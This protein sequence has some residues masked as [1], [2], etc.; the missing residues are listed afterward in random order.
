MGE[1]TS[2]ALQRAAGR[3]RYRPLML[4]GLL[5]AL[6]VATYAA[7][8]GNR[9]LFHHAADPYIAPVLDNSM[10]QSFPLLPKLFCRSFLLSTYGEYRP[11]GYALL[12]LVRRILPWDSGVAWHGALIALH[13]LTALIVFLTLRMLVSDWA[14]SALSAAYLV[15]PI[16]VFLVNN[17][18][19][20]YF[21]WGLCFSAL[22]LWL[23]LLYLR[24]NGPAYLLVSVV[25]FVVAAF[26]FRHAAVLPA[27]VIVLCLHHAPRP[28]TAAAM[29]V[30]VALAAS[31]AA[32]FQVPV[33]VTLGALCA[34]MLSAGMATGAGK[35]QYLDLAR[36]LPPYVG[37]VALY[38]FV[39]LT[40][41][42]EPLHA[43]TL[44][45][46]KE[47]DMVAPVQPEW[48]WR[49]AHAGSALLLVSFGATVF[50]PLLLLSKRLSR[51][52]VVL[53]AFLCFVS[54]RE[55]LYYR[56]DARYWGRLARL[57]PDHAAVQ[58]NLATALV[59]EG[60]YGAARDLLIRLIVERGIRLS[61]ESGFKNAPL[62]LMVQVKLAEAYA[63]LG[64]DK[65]AGFYFFSATRGHWKFR[66]MRNL[67]TE[68]GDFCFRTG[69]ISVAE[70]NWASGLVLDPYDVR[71]YNN[72]GRTL[73][74]RNFFRAA[75]RHFEYVLSLQPDNVTALYYMA[76]L[77]KVLGRQEDH[78]AYCRRWRA[79]THSAGEPDFQPI[80][81]GFRF[82]PDKMRA[83]FSGNPC[84]MSF[85]LQ[86][87]KAQ[88][89][90]KTYSF[91]E[92]PLSIARYLV[93]QG[94]YT[95]AETYLQQ[96]HEANPGSREAIQ[97]LIEVYG[98][99]NR[100]D[101]AKRMQGLLE[102]LP[103][104]NEAN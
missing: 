95:D 93:G 67:L 104:G 87:Y 39:S 83:W 64:D 80:Y 7:S 37:V 103:S 75:A 33:L 51:F 1:S 6:G 73:T 41:K 49:W 77:S 88:Y 52:V 11:A 43:V 79:V 53:L 23:C 18:N 44:E 21:L 100:P 82:D 76:F 60:D 8:L 19:Q 47:A 78:A 96:A 16:L 98:R 42:P 20:M 94:R 56:D 34:L 85:Q 13:L 97:L 63:G 68:A 38:V 99:L 72:L 55:S 4:V 14:A 5:I 17:V 90:G 71:L 84:E 2:Q 29:L 26:A 28:R 32:V 46:L 101:D 74:Y 89:E 30:C 36:V 69:Y 35:E 81:D 48:V 59:N 58:V 61:Y 86:G 45:V 3:P 12:A 65:T 24:T 22:T 57:R 25:A 91:W 27:F 15:H 9:A 31:A 10:V 92:A 102:A 70:Y 50:F 54:V 40:V 62:P 66:M